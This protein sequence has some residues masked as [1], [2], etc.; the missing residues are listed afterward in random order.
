MNSIDYGMNVAE[1]TNAPAFHHQWLP[2]EL[3]VE[4][5]FSPDTIKLLEAKGQKVALER[6]DGQYTKH[7]GWAGR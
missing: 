4:K 5:G 1:A 3:R 2:D 7:Y 6:G